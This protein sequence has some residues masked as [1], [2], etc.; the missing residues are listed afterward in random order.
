MCEDGSESEV[1]WNSRDGQVPIEIK[2]AKTGR[3]MTR[4]MQNDAFEPGYV[5]KVGERI[6]VDITEARARMFAARRLELAEQTNPA[7][8]HAQF[9]SRQEALQTIFEQ[10]N[11]PGLTDILVVTAGYLEELAE[12]RR[13]GDPV[14]RIVQ[15]AQ[16]LELSVVFAMGEPPPDWRGTREPTQRIFDKQLRPISWERYA[17]LREDYLYVQV[18]HDDVDE[19]TDVSTVWTGFDIGTTALQAPVVFETMIWRRLPGSFEHEPSERY[20]WLDEA[21]ARA[22]HRAVLRAEQAR[23]KKKN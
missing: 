15:S 17:E 1:L 4:V 12:V 21:S 7:E 22:G 19:N 10:V 9:A 2:S 3:P 23:A 14:E 8:L 11:V 16:E 13:K 20:N 5:P 6:F 18:D